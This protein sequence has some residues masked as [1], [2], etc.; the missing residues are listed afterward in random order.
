MY[1]LFFS[2]SVLIV[3]TLACAFAADPPSYDVHCN[4]NHPNACYIQ[5]HLNIRGPSVLNFINAGAWS[6]VEFIDLT[7]ASTVTNIPNGIFRQFQKLTKLRL[8]SGLTTITRDN[9]QSAKQLKTLQLEHNKIQVLPSYVF[10]DASNLEE[11]ALFANNL[12]KIEDNA[13]SGLTNLRRL[14]LQNNSLSILKHNTFTGAENLQVLQLE[15]NRIE[16]IEDLSL[17]LP[18]LE[19]LFLGY[20]RIRT[21][22]DRFFS[23]TP[24]LVSVSMEGNGIQ[25]IGQSFNNLRR[26]TSLNLNGNRI[27]DLDLMALG[28]LPAINKLYLRDSGF[29]LSVYATDS[30]MVSQLIELDLTN[31]SIS[32]SNILQRLK[33]F[34]KLAV[35]DLE[36]N[37]L[38]EL[39][40]LF[41]VRR[42]YPELATLRL[43]GNRFSCENFEIILQ[44]LLG[45]RIHVRKFPGACS[46]L[47]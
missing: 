35:L 4:E 45:Q 29:K 44:T 23:G 19:H 20:N 47:Y 41:N 15:S 46:N 6:N 3:A 37:E 2:P 43:A 12:Q 18:S 13:F 33:V 21:L 5:E 38:R 31:N 8:S 9:F 28:R 40:G 32:A 14:Y 39:D 25:A 26:L 36:N 11:I 1:F 7:P 30:F 34:N 27:A 16:V 22:G 17:Q 42:D 24:N 10:A